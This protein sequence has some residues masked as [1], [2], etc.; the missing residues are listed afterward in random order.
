AALLDDNSMRVANKA[1]LSGG[2]DGGTNGWHFISVRDG[3]GLDRLVAEIER[4]AEALLGGREA[5][6]ITRARHRAAVEEALVHLE[7]FTRALGRG[8]LEFLAEDLRLAARALGRIT[9][10]IE[11]DDILD[12]IFSEFCIGK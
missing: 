8:E 11:V 4:R 7:R 1:D 6:L 3:Q 5:V 10:R 2:R 9:G 12:V